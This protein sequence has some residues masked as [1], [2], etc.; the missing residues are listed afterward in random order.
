MK[1]T[2]RQDIEAPL[3]FVHEVLTD[4][5]G[6]ERAAMRRGADVTR[7]DTLS[8][9]GIGMSWQSSFKFRGKERNI[10]LALKDWDAPGRLGFDGGSTAIGGNA[11]LDLIEMSANH[12]RLHVGL[13]VTPKTMGARL[14][15]Q[16]IR[17]ARG[18]MDRHFDQRVAQMAAEIENRYRA[19]Q[20]R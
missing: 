3:A 10:H 6:W 2:T 15:L 19:S 4:F 7:T 5:D 9:P 20:R 16:S 18:R 1:L 8:R 11:V 14:F 17:L 13:E 12:T